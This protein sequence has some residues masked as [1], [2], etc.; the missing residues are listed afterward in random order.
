M[1]KILFFLA[2]LSLASCLSTPAKRPPLSSMLRSSNLI[3]AFTTIRDVIRTENVEFKESY[4]VDTQFA[5]DAN[6][7]YETTYMKHSMDPADLLRFV[8]L[9]RGYFK[10]TD[11]QSI[12]F[13]KTGTNT[14]KISFE[15]GV[16]SLQEKNND[17]HVVECDDSDGN[18]K[19]KSELVYS[20]VLNRN[21]R[22][23]TVVF[24]GSVTSRDWIQNFEFW[25]VLPDEVKGFAKEG[26]KMHRGFCD[27]LFEYKLK[28]EVETKY[29]RIVKSLR[30]IYT[31]TKKGYDGIEDYSLY[32]TGHSLGG[33]MAQILAFTLA[34][35][36]LD[37]LPKDKPVRAI[38]FA[39]P[40]VGDSGY[41]ASFMELEKASKLRHIR[42]SNQGDAVPIVFNLT[43]IHTFEQPGV[44]VHV[45][46]DNEATVQYNKINKFFVNPFK[47]SKRHTP[48]EYRQH[49]F[50]VKENENLI[51]TSTRKLYEDY[52]E[53]QW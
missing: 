15:E 27:Y 37:F 7:I 30:E 17:V 19:L 26:T 50:G 2:N 53:P 29:E 47:A 24:R 11:T 14:K 38:T 33:A 1:K 31:S 3:Y 42:V 8:D 12:L 9:N 25:G 21:E 22:R 43:P 35:S 20:I 4:L 48:L 40:E 13:D 16:E 28:N 41:V 49:L 52:A 5:P 10:E 23:V 39:S 51:N 6:R 18:E 34:G 32:V 36:N 46:K 45:Y 44:N